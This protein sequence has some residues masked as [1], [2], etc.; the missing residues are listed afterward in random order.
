MTEMCLQ[1]SSGSRISSAQ[2]YGDSV[3]SW[4]GSGIVLCLVNPNNS[5]THKLIRSDLAHKLKTQVQDED[6]D[7]IFRTINEALRA[8]HR[9]K[10]QLIKLK[11]L[12]HRLLPTRVSLC[13]KVE[14]HSGSGRHMLWNEYRS[15]SERFF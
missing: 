11:V 10:P 9:V 1:Y 5:D 8:V 12:L 14:T 13:D 15:T 2:S 6:T 7:M 3:S 4:I